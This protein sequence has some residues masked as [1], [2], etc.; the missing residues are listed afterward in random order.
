MFSFDQ[1]A[2]WLFLMLFQQQI[3][4]YIQVTQKSQ[5]PAWWWNFTLPSSWTV[6]HHEMVL[7]FLMFYSPGITDLSISRHFG[8]LPAFPKACTRLV[9]PFPNAAQLSRET[10]RGHTCLVYFPYRPS[11]Q[12]CFVF[13]RTL[14]SIFHGQCNDGIQMN[15]R[16]KLFLKNREITK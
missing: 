7:S 3:Y 4:T 12:L 1:G 2:N 9:I 6:S 10:C 13:L 16:D 14:Y 8:H 11:L 15:Q 5:V